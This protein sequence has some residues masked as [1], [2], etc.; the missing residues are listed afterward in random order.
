MSESNNWYLYVLQCSDESLYTG[1]T[2]DLERRVHEHNHTKQG[3]KYTKSRRPVQL[4]TSWSFGSQSKAMQAEAAFK[5]LRRPQKVALL[6]TTPEQLL[7]NI[8]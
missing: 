8:A 1:V 7:E 3:A 4:V 2:T 5:Q 6:E